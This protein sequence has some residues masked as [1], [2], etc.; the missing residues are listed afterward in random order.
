MQ[1]EWCVR[2]AIGHSTMPEDDKIRKIQR[3]GRDK[4]D[5]GFH[6][7]GVTNHVE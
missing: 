6:E 2:D 1:E 4:E 3:G 5:V 7:A